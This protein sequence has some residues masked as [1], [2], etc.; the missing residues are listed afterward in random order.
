MKRVLF[1]WLLLLALMLAST[2]CLLSWLGSIPPSR[3]TTEIEAVDLGLP[4]GVKWG[5]MN[6]LS[7]SDSS[8]GW[9]FAWGETK[10][11]EYS[12]DY[13]FISDGKL[14]AYNSDPSMGEVDNRYL[15][16]PED[17]AATVLIGEEWRIPTPWEF[18]EL[19]EYCSWKLE[20]YG[21]MNG[22][23]ISSKV[24][25][26]SIFLPVSRHE[27]EKSAPR[28]ITVTAHMSEAQR[29]LLQPFWERSGAL[30]RQKNFVNCF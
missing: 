3:Q 17:D 12:Q 26:N 13:I 11:K 18:Q 1:R 4:S 14:T 20:V 5:S 23:R 28:T 8:L 6:L 9:D 27:G 15:L 24:N 10:T 7:S 22:Y 21:G 30:L 25:S 2:S 19:L 16:D 29:I